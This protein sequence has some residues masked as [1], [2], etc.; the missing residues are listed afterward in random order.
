[1]ICMVIYWSIKQFFRFLAV[2]KSEPPIVVHVWFAF[3]ANTLE[4]ETRKESPQASNDK[5]YHGLQNPKTK[6]ESS[7]RDVS[8]AF[9]LRVLS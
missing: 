9:L 5:I 1:M 7:T 6:I 4:T 2:I 8:Y 3:F